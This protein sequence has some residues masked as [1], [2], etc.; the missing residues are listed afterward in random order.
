MSTSYPQNDSTLQRTLRTPVPSGHQLLTLGLASTAQAAVTCERDIT[1]NVVA[2][3][4]PILF[5]RLG[6]SNVNAAIFALE[7]DVVDANGVPLSTRR[8]SRSRDWCSCVPT[9]APARWCCGYAVA[10]A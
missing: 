7:R 5:N 6:A 3:D 2:L 10:T 8:R 1:A 4:Q 9:S